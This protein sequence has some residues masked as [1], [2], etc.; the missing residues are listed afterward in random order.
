MPRA[1]IIIII[2]TTRCTSKFCCAYTDKSTWQ[3]PKHDTHQ[4]N[5]R[6]TLVVPLE[7]WAD[8]SNQQNKQ[9]NDGHTSRSCNKAVSHTHCCGAHGCCG[10]NS[11]A[12]HTTNKEAQQLH[13]CGSAGSAYSTQSMQL[14]HTHN[15][16]Y[17]HT[18]L[19]WAAEGPAGPAPHTLV[20]FWC[21]SGHCLLRSALL[22]SDADIG[23]AGSDPPGM[24]VTLPADS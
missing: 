23:P 1:L 21:S 10:V 9:T 15:L 12:S 11:Y 24:S 14:A 3:V 8:H 7:A 2:I 4:A 19:K 6:F 20:V 16:R 18:P 22:I 17:L 5:S 13:L